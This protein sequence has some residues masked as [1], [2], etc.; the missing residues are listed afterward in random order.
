[1]ELSEYDGKRV[2]IELRNGFYYKGLVLSS[3]EDYI[4]I[5]DKED[6]MIFIRVDNIVFIKE[7]DL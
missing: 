4:K 2:K 3:G 5:R 6:K 1:M 7:V